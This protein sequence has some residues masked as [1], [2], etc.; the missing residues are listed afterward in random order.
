MFYVK[1]FMVIIMLDKS[2]FE[3]CELLE[4]KESISYKE[5]NELYMQQDLK[6]SRKITFDDK[7]QKIEVL[8][9]IDDKQ[10]FEIITAISS[11]A[12]AGAFKAENIVRGKFSS[13]SATKDKAMKY[14]ELE[15][16]EAQAYFKLQVGKD[17]HD[18]LQ[19]QEALD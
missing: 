2:I 6:I 10:A 12:D 16:D 3:I 11:S 4:T 7:T 19:P 1:I 9:Y 17:L 13:I 8:N 15:P 5:F 18:F 14:I